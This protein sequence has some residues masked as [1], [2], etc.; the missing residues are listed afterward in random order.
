M[1]PYYL[2]HESSYT[3]K[4]SLHWDIPW[5][6]ASYSPTHLD[7]SI[8]RQ[9]QCFLSFLGQKYN[10]NYDNVFN[11]NILSHSNFACVYSSRQTHKIDQELP[12]SMGFKATG[13]FWNPLIS[14]SFSKCSF[15]SNKGLVGIWNDRKAQ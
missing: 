3:D 11:R 5:S 6:P 2:Y 7:T 9:N 12:Y 4:I 8:W 1:R 13:E 10:K 14:T 15:I